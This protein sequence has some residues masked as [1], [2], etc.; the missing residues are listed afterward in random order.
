MLA[1]P[2][3][4]RIGR[5]GAPLR[6]GDH[7]LDLI[8]AKAPLLRDAR[9]VGLLEEVKG[10]IRPKRRTRFIDH[11]D[12]KPRGTARGQVDFAAI[13]QGVSDFH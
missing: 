4:N 1:T 8:R 9:P 12:S 10:G 11:L 6:G 3:T 2:P 5:R 7:R 13:G